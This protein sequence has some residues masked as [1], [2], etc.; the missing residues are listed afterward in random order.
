MTEQEKIDRYIR[1]KGITK[2]PPVTEE[3][4]WD[5]HLKQDER[6]GYSP[7]GTIEKVKKGRK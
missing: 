6:T 5:F 1:T 3:T 4:F 7:F 2:L